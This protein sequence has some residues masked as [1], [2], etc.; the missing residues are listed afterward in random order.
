MAT[1]LTI[2]LH[3]AQFTS[4]RTVS[5]GD[6]QKPCHYA[7]ESHKAPLTNLV[8]ARIRGTLEDQICSEPLQCVY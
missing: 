6:G 8:L 4:S 3:S 1:R 2:A 5:E 7:T